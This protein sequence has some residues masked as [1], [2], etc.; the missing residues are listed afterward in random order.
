M[1]LYKESGID[2]GRIEN[3]A[4]AFEMAKAEN[5]ERSKMFPLNKK[6]KI[7]RANTAAETVGIE[8]VKKINE[9]EDELRDRA[10]MW[11][12]V[13]GLDWNMNEIKIAQ[14]K[15]LINTALDTK[16]TDRDKLQRDIDF[17]NNEVT[18]RTLDEF[19]GLVRSNFINDCTAENI[20]TITAG[21]E[22][23][24]IDINVG[25]F[26]NNRNRKYFNL[27]INVNKK[28]VGRWQRTQNV[29]HRIAEKG[30]FAP[31]DKFSPNGYFLDGGQKIPII[32]RDTAINGGIYLGGS[33][34][35]AIVVDEDHDPELNN[36][37]NE[38]VAELTRQSHGQG[39]LGTQELL[40]II[41]KNAVAKMRYD[42]R[43]IAEIADHFSG[44][45]KIALGY[46]LSRQIGV[47]RQQALLVGYVI[48]RLIRERKS[49]GYISVDRNELYAGAHVWARYTSAKNQIYILDPAQ[50][51]CGRIEDVKYKKRAW[52]YKRPGEK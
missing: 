37:Y 11:G 46:F 25:N 50:K 20:T 23:V 4:V 30:K 14:I 43:A 9:R 12:S 35:E 41:F 17:I 21:N 19:N 36:F 39:S 51:Y 16:Y 49:N 48:E 6:E 10:I 33:E 44:D 52:S 5:V 27:F 47:C 24:D 2:R 32:G 34:R 22:L 26:T 13:E 8:L 31:P 7:N 28:Q 1:K 42:G 18:K 29:A 3:L 40:D 15:S 45:Q 38:V